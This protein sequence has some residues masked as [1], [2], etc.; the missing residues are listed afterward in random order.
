MDKPL[1]IKREPLSGEP[2]R[3]INTPPATNS[4]RQAHLRN[5][6][7][8]AATAL[9]GF[10]AFSQAR[11]TL[12]NPIEVSSPY[13]RFPQ[14]DDAFQ[15]IPCSHNHHV[16]QLDDRDHRQTWASRFNPDPES[17]S[18][19]KKMHE[20]VDKSDPHAG[21]GIFLCGY[22]DVPLD[23][24]NETDTR[25][26]RLAVTKYQ[27]SGLARL[28]SE[29]EDPNAG[30]KSERT[31]II[32]PGGPGGSGVRAAWNMAQHRA[33]LVTDGKFDVLGWDP[34]GVNASLPR[35]SCFPYDAERDRWSLLSG[36][37][38]AAMGNN[39]ELQLVTADAM[40][41]AT[42]R[43]CKD[44][45]GDLPRFVSTAFVARDVDR[46]L[47]ALDEPDLT[48]LFFSYGTGIGQ[49]FA[50]MFP[51]RVG[52]LILDGVEY[53]R[54]QRLVGGFGYAALDNATDAWNDGFLGECLKAGPGSCHLAR[55]I[56]GSDEPV[57]YISLKTRMS[58][59]LD[60]LIV[61]PR[62]TYLTKSGPSLITYSQVVG[63]IL[64]AM[65]NSQSWP[66]LAKAMFDLEQ[67]RTTMMA[68]LLERQ[69]Q[70]KPPGHCPA[71][72]RNEGKTEELL[73]FVVCADSYDSP[74]PWSDSSDDAGPLSWWA[75]LWQNMT[76][77]NWIAG[78]DRFYNVLPCR[79]FTRHFGAPA[80]VYRGDLNNTL[81]NPVL[82]IAETYDPAT[83]IRNARRL[84][85]EMGDNARL[86]AHHGYGH[87]SK[88][89]STCTYLIARN[90]IVH[91]VLPEASETECF[92]DG[93][94]Y[95]YELAPEKSR[96]DSSDEDE[97]DFHLDV[98]RQHQE[99][100]RH[101]HP[102]VGGYRL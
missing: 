78:D 93:K 82:L 59:L 64:G 16:P 81:S 80:E 51:N 27:V 71:L 75:D 83:P 98:W 72:Q 3:S 74:K 35:A 65:Y 76:A 69:W 47:T 4:R 60:S 1:L 26:A 86:I 43:G 14:P 57:S 102:G 53:V 24:T 70:F 39:S 10:H 85:A 95:H 73:P 40:N 62:P 34:R 25:I 21:H 56:D 50:N 48:G 38:R 36:Q 96:G 101:Y 79:H 45:L 46:I 89:R 9:L 30:R 55:Q 77:Q 54:D 13:G 41:D 7:V 17:W 19:G 94:P 32:N 58:N 87:S 100:M 11:P 22:L 68:K 49:T 15:F 31:L 66:A 63:T 42:F 88:D 23:Y 8:F 84:L 37:S 44:V 12:N 99:E 18:W 28:D 29:G 61:Q 90:Y 97:N 20:P 91:G 52:R 5:M 2:I 33:D 67:G 6:L 92:A